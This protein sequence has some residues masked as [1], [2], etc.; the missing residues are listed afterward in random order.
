V[1]RRVPGLE[2]PV[3]TD[4]DAYRAAA[5]AG[6]VGQEVPVNHSPGFA[7]ILQPTLDT[8]T[9]ALIVATLARLAR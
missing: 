4:P 8:G 1:T 7:P 9:Q 5:E 3:G 6:R 2:L